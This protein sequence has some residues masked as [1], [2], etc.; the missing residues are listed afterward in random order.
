MAGFAQEQ[1]A[2][3]EPGWEF[4]EMRGHSPSST[5]QMSMDEIFPSPYAGTH[6]DFERC[7]ST[8]SYAGTE[9]AHSPGVST[10]NQSGRMLP[11]F[12]VA[13][14][15]RGRH[16]LRQGNPSTSTNAPG[17]P[18]LNSPN[19]F[20]PAAHLAHLGPYSARTMESNSFGDRQHPP[21]HRAAPARPQFGNVSK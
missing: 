15:G 13:D 12:G 16:D 3:S 11:G 7:A 2:G 1:Q 6:D 21:S 5:S 14:A 9:A 20:V 8:T 19:G 17:A 18:T 4:V 10:W